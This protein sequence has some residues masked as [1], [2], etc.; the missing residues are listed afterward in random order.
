VLF[1]SSNELKVITFQP[2]YSEINIKSD[3]AE[4]VLLSLFHSFPQITCIDYSNKL[5]LIVATSKDSFL[6]VFEEKQGYATSSSSL[7]LHTTW[8]LK[9]KKKADQQ[10][11]S[12]CSI[13]QQSDSVVTIGNEKVPRIWC[14][15]KG[16]MIRNLEIIHEIPHSLLSTND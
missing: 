1:S 3:F 12:L 13:Q 10:G 15:K 4:R 11:V 6:R 2:T 16:D 8:L 5:N 9:H 7:Q 14:L